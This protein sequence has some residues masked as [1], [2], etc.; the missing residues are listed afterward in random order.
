MLKL[1][2][3]DSFEAAHYLPGHPKCSQLHGHTYKVEVMIETDE[4]ADMVID[5]GEL[6]VKLREALS[7]YDHKLLNEV[8]ERLPTTENLARILHSKLNAALPRYRLT[9][10]VWEGEDKW[11]EYSK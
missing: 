8:M 5:F 11:A 4:E 2:V 7:E 10:R 1:C 6:R 9:V 3:T